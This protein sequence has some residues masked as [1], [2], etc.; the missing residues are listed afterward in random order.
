M[1]TGGTPDIIQN[2][3]T[4]LLS[5]T[6][7]EFAADIRRLRDDPDLRARLGAAARARAFTAFDSSVVIPRIE[8]LYRDL[9]ARAA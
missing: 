4:G 5:R 9:L 1:N 6:L 3:E 7:E 8:R 2:G